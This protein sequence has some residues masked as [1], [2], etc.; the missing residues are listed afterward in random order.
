MNVKWY[1]LEFCFAT[2]S[3]F[4]AFQRYILHLHQFGCNLRIYL[5]HW[6]EVQKASP[7]LLLVYLD[8]EPD[9]IRTEIKSAQTFLRSNKTKG[10]RKLIM[11]AR[12]RTWWHGIHWLYVCTSITFLSSSWNKAEKRFSPWF[13]AQAILHSGLLGLCSLLHFCVLPYTSGS[14]RVVE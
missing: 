2:F 7:M 10:M 5:L 11:Q 14:K 1:F 9:R 6:A 8:T 12:S 3:T 13:N 4:H